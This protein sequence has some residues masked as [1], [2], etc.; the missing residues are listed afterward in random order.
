MKTK[1]KERDEKRGREISVANLP[2]DLTIQDPQDYIRKMRSTFL[3]RVREKAGF[4]VET[5][6]KKCG[7]SADELNRI[8]SGKVHGQDMMVL[9]ALAE[10]YDIDY[11]CLLFMFK[12]AK[13]QAEENALKMAAHHN[14]RIDDETQGKILSFIEKI[15]ESIG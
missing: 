4:D 12:L 5:V 1:I 13:P 3:A 8:E 14:Q 9:N 15:K 6:A 10:I 7:I 2:H 11:A